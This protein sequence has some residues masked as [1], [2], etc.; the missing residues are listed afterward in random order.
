M[1]DGEKIQNL[2]NRY[3]NGERDAVNDLYKLYLPK[4]YKAVQDQEDKMNMIGELGLVLTRC[5]DKYDL[6]LNIMFNTYFWSSW[7][8]ERSV[9]HTRSKAKKRQFLN[10]NNE[11][12]IVVESIYNNYDEQHQKVEMIEDEQYRQS[13]EYRMRRN[14]FMKYIEGSSLT[15]KEKFILTSIYDGVKQIDIA[16]QLGKTP[17]S[18]S[19]ILK[20]IQ[21]RPY[22]NDLKRFLKEAIQ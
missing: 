21:N 11:I 18:V 7:Q 13:M 19:F 17:A 15:D 6:S 1:T 10:N 2:V 22:A 8:N 14:D 3:L 9:H 4:F 16:K 5:L 12:K 20:N